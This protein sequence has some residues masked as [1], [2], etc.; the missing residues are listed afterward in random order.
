MI[1]LTLSQDS[2]AVVNGES[3][4]NLWIGDHLRIL[5][6][7]VK[8]HK[9]KTKGPH[10]LLTSINFIST[11]FKAMK[12]LDVFPVSCTLNSKNEVKV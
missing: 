8:S 6:K 3:D 1:T 12:H 11:T 9:I 5:K 4:G 2:S 7:N 10:R